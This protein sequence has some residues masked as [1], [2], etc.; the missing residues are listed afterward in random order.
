MIT[1]QSVL[2]FK[3]APTDESMTAHAGLAMFGEFLQAMGIGHVINAELPEPGSARG[4]KPSAFVTPLILMMHGGG[5]TLEDLREIRNDTG[6]LTLLQMQDALPSSD[7]TGDWL[8]RMG[9]DALG[10]LQRMNNVVTRPRCLDT[11]PLSPA[12]RHSLTSRITCRRPIPS[13]SAPSVCRSLF[14]ATSLITCARPRSFP[15]ISSTC[16]DG[17]DMSRAMLT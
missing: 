15:L 17:S 10:S 14:S 13:R 12:L 9:K 1:A 11:S 7:A 8:R 2:P 5:R 3:L 16:V 4:Y 6:L